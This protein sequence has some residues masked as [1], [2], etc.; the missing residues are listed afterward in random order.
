MHKII[1]YIE[2]SILNKNS[3]DVSVSQFIRDTDFHELI[4]TSKFI[5]QKYTRDKLL[6]MPNAVVY[7]IYWAKGSYS[8]PHNHPKG[9]CILKV[10]N[11]ALC[12][13]SYDLVENMAVCTDD[14]KLLV[15]DSIGTKYGNELHS[16]KAIDDTVSIHIYFPGNYTPTF[17]GCRK[18]V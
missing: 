11:G 2:Q 7:L 6:D 4:D 3:I 1:Q 12:E 13:T 5:E 8:P 10:L 16:I 14:S 9:G 18:S 15:K 17:F